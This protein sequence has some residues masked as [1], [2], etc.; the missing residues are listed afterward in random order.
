M[1][2]I[3]RFLEELRGNPEA[4]E[5]L[6]NRTKPESAEEEARGYTEVARKLGYDFTEDDL[7]AYAKM[8]A[9]AMR[10]KTDRTAD[11]LR[12]L[13][14]GELDEAAGGGRSGG[15]E[16]N[17]CSAHYKH[18]RDCIFTYMDRENCYNFDG[19]DHYFYFYD[20]YKCHHTPKQ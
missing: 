6:K 5:L 14:E 12:E 3:V 20:G 10:E 16:S 17:Q 9:D 19:C 7:R 11:D 2:R 1:E 13:P 8:T 4:Q 18:K 15:G